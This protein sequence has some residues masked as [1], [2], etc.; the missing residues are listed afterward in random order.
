MQITFFVAKSKNYF[1]R[2]MFKMHSQLKIKNR[3]LGR[4]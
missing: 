4:Y 1:I 2:K 3:C